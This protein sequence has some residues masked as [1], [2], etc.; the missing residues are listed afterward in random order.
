MTLPSPLVLGALYGVSEII[1]GFTRRSRGGSRDQHSL[2]LLWGVILVSIALAISSVSLYPA[3]T[4]PHQWFFYLIGLVLF[5]GGIILR[6]YSIVH[7]GRFFTVD[8]SIAKE[9]RVVDS[10]PYRFIRHPSYT[11]ALLAFAG[12]GLSL[13]NWLSIVFMTL[14]ITFAF[15]WRIRIEERALIDALG[16]DYRVYLRRTARL[17]PFVY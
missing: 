4:L 8:V 15:L 5:V 6:W 12:I 16:D 9:H 3:A 13:G 14:P 1:L 7:L 11:G 17:I 10:G 2:A